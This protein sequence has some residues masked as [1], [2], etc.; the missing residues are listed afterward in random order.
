M[1][2]PQCGTENTADS[3]FCGG[4]G[5]KLTSEPSRVAPTAK[6]P[7]DA[8]FPPHYGGSPMPISQA[9]VSPQGPTT[10]SPPTY[11]PASIPPQNNS[12]ATYGTGPASI[13]PQNAYAAGP[14][15]IPPS[16]NPYPPM[17][18]RPMAEP[19]MSMPAVQ[20]PRWGLIISI[21]IVDLGLA[22]A[23]AF[24]LM[25]GLA[26]PTPVTEPAKSEP[27]AVKAAEAPS[28]QPAP[29]QKPDVAASI[30]AAANGSAAGSG[31]GSAAAV[32]A[33][34]ATTPTPVKRSAAAKKPGGAAPQDPYAE[35]KPPKQLATEVELAMTR[36]KA[37]LGYCHEDAGTVHG[38][39][40]IAFEVLPSGTVDNVE[41]RSNTT[42]SQTLA[43]CLVQVITRWAFAAKPPAPTQIVRPFIY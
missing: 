19:S 39:I 41:A 5:A 30:M 43:T 18:A 27:A 14:A 13:P 12:V 15:S 33:S 38:R 6:I 23:G 11:S 22:G 24:M 2:C 37:E 25:K 17:S 16:N 10:L 42:G 34:A 31:S 40:D 21:L 8:P 32:D 36:S 20:S 7:D 29:P 26:K 9:P 4:C 35:V 28:M 1:R 3:R